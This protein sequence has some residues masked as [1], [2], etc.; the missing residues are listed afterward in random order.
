ME[1]PTLIYLVLFVVALGY[2]LLSE[3]L[4]SLR[5]RLALSILALGVVS[6]IVPFS[7]P[8]LPKQ[9]GLSI[10]AFDVGQADCIL[11]STPN[12]KRYMID[13]G[14]MNF[15][16]VPEAERAVLPLLQAE[17]I[18]GIDAGFITH[19]HR[20]HYGGAPF[21]LQ[22]VGMRSLYWTG[23]R[24]A[25][26]LAH[27]L[28]HAV[29]S[30]STQALRL[31]MGERISLDSDVI[32]YVLH[33]PGALVDTRGPARGVRLNNGSL[34]VKIVYRNTSALFLGDIEAIDEEMLVREYGDFLK[35]DVVKVAHHG[36]AGSSDQQFI[37]DVNP[38]FAFISVGEH[39]KFGHP[40]PITL[41]RWQKSGAKILRTDR[42][43]AILLESDGSKFTQR[44]WRL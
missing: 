19:M 6:L 18:R 36:S 39:N 3:D 4:K 23:E 14:S 44:D 22:N 35:S 37:T 38:K 29:I 12:G 27:E 7:E 30:T 34:V 33:P 42:D 41:Q 32:L 5:S 1:K 21:L 17:G 11:I 10:L 40:T 2:L 8:I 16:H 20:D 28:D 15:S 13:F 24:V 31:E 43:G 25:D 26:S 9:N